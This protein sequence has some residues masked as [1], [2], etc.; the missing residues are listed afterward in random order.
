MADDIDAGRCTS[1]DQTRK[2]MADKIFANL[3][4]LTREEFAPTTTPSLDSIISQ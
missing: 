4:R 3:P 2:S 1:I